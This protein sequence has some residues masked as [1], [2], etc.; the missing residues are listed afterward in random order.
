MKKKKLAGLLSF[1]MIFSL[2]A[3]GGSTTTEEPAPTEEPAVE[4]TAEP[5]AGDAKT[6]FAV[7]SSV[8]KSKDAAEEDGLAQTDSL[9]VAVIVDKDGKIV[10]AVIDSAQTKINFSKEGKITTD[11][12]TIFK[13]K[14]DMGEEYGM[15]KASSIGKEWNEQAAAFADYVKGKT[16]EEIKGIAVT[17][18][19]VPT[20][21]DIKGSVTVKVKDF[22]AGIEKAAANAKEIGAS[23]TDKLGI[24]IE[25]NIAKSKDAGDEA[26]LAQAYSTYV[27]TTTDADGK[28]TS[29]IIDGSQANI[30]FDATG[31]ITSD[32]TAE[33]KTKQELGEGYGMK[34]A[35]AIG[36]EWNEQADAFAEF[37]KGK[38]ADEVKGMK[39]SADGLTEE[40][41]LKSSVTVH[42]TDFIKLTEASVKKAN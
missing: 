4:E 18:E 2:T 17:E 16:V 20:G 24:A 15:K 26:G 11:L 41:E 39:V 34:K 37:I 7:I 33:L 6:G 28:I 13:S 21:D 10:N 42:V 36:K 14:V 32:L 25:T 5:A 19:G 12:A 9:A 29:A 8:A 27:V 22:I 38:T 40:E 23:S 30:N 35:S 31:K 3:C 1:A